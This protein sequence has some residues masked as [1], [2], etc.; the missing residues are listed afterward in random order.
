MDEPSCHCWLN[1]QI[2]R[3]E[4]Y[5]YSIPKSS[6]LFTSNGIQPAP[7]DVE[8]LL[9]FLTPVIAYGANQSPDSLLRK[10][11][12][13]NKPL[14]IPVLRATAKDVDV[15]FLSDI[16]P[17]GCI[18]A[19]IHQSIGSSTDVA[20][21]FLNNEELE[22]MDRTEGTHESLY[23]R[24]RMENQCLTVD[25]IGNIS[26]AYA[27]IGLHG[28]LLSECGNPIPLQA[29]QSS[30]SPLKRWTQWEVLSLVH[31]RVAPDIEF[32]DF[33]KKLATCTDSRQGWGG[34]LRRWSIPAELPG[35][36][37]F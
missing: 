7:D 29:I 36:T 18:P 2:S 8:L 27:Y 30:G 37:T 11:S 31:S 16:S 9:E 33:E 15:I 4:N 5:P 34:Q 12:N 20:V 23:R 17:Y 6:Y 24:V 1:Q 25:G 21:I 14:A 19:T 22:L 3:I 32:L 13:W 26:S 28:G 35:M 10:F